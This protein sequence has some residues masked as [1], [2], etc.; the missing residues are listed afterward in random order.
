MYQQEQQ[1]PRQMRQQRHHGTIASELAQV[2]ANLTATGGT[3]TSI[4][5]G[6]QNLDTIIQNG[7]SGLTSELNPADTATLN[8]IVTSS[9]ALAAQAAAINTTPPSN[10]PPPISAP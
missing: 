1:R 4:A 6:V 7:I 2:Q 3:L 8:G 9:A 5:A 10:P